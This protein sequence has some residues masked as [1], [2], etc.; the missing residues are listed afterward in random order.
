MALAASPFS[1]GDDSDRSRAAAVLGLIYAWS[2]FAVMW[3]FWISFVIFLASPSRLAVWWPLPM[4]DVGGS[5]G[6]PAGAALV[7]LAL[8][9]LFGLQHSLMARPWFKSLWARSIPAAFERCTYVHMANIA[10][11]LLILLWQPIPI[12]VWRITGDLPRAFMW[13]AFGLGWVILFAGAVS[14]GILDLLGV[15]QMRRWY[16]GQRL[17]AA[18]LKTGWLYRWLRHPM[19]LGVLLGVW[20]TPRMTVGH[21]LLALSLTA[22]VLIALR[23]EERDLAERFGGR[24][25]LWRAK[26]GASG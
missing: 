7:D 12:D 5:I 6:P 8:I 10:L 26:P 20:A 17:T 24:Y 22:Y 15:D 2:G 14:F 3:A 23:Y 25:L 4:V 13:V 1:V 18:G 9:G 16:V 11:F 19:Y 21:A